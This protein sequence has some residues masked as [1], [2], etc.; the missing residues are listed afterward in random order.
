MYQLHI[1]ECEKIANTKS[2]NRKGFIDYS[3]RTD[4][5]YEKLE[6]YNPTKKVLTVFHDKRKK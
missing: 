1:N 5:V 2:K 4:D 3:E 6:E